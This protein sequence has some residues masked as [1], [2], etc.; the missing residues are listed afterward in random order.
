MNDA[1]QATQALPITMEEPEHDPGQMKTIVVFG[2]PRDG[3]RCVGPFDTRE[4][5][6]DWA[7]DNVSRG[8]DWWLVP[9]ATPEEKANENI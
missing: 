6:S 7:D 8:Y 2:N 9:L 1:T 4:Q 3:F 5:A